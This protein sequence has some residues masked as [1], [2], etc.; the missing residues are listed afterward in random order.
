VNQADVHLLQAGQ[1]ARISL[2]AYPGLEFK[3]RVQHVAPVGTTS[4]LTDR[5][6]N[7][8]AI[9]TIEGNHP[10]LMPDLSAAVD[11]E[12]ER[13]DN[14]IVLPRDAIVGEENSFSVRV[15]DGN[16]VRE[17]TVS[18][19]AVNDHE[20]VVTSGLEPGTTVQR[21]VAH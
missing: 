14:V 16:R 7:F 21:Y 20:V 6:R 15:M 8:V 18:I 17:R 3:G 4:R 11:V 1:P 13:K 10:K 5:V 19:G 2:D 9:V 12:L